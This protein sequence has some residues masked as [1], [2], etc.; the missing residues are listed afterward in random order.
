MKQPTYEEIQTRAT[1][2]IVGCVLI[3]FVTIA[4]TWD[5]QFQ[6]QANECRQIGGGKWKASRSGGC[7][8]VEKN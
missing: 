6:K 4:W 2:L 5:V 7:Y 8:L 3:G 1:E